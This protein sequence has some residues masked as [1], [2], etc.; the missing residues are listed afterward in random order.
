[1]N[2]R[3]VPGSIALIAILG[4]GPAVPGHCQGLG[5]LAARARADSNDE[6]LH[7]QVAMGFWKEKNWDEAETYLRNA[8]AVAPQFDR[9][10]LALG[11]LPWVRGQ[12]YWK[13]FEKMHGHEATDSAIATYAEFGRRAFLV[14]PLVDR[15]IL[16]ELKGGNAVNVGPLSLRARWIGQMRR[17]ATQVHLG[18]PAGAYATLDSA[19]HDPRFPSIYQD[20][21]F[22]VLFYHGLAAAG[23]KNWDQAIEDFGIITGR[24]VK[25]ERD[26]LDDAGYL[27][28]Q[29]N[30]FRYALATMLYLAGRHEQ[31][32][33]VFRRVLEVDLGVFPAHVQLARIHEAAG[34]AEAGIRERKQAIEVFPQNG[35]LYLELSQA[36]F[37]AGHGEDAIQTLVDG[38]AV[39]RRDYR[40]PLLLGEMLMAAGRDREARDAYIRFMGIAP[41]RLGAQVAEVRQTVAQIQ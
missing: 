14:N 24:G 31:A 35:T 8:V 27:R 28:Y 40:I 5:E 7:Y 9:A 6:Q 32:V 16:G 20:V 11:E 36:Q 41:L 17:G 15:A 21:P 10:L 39:N 2:L 1:M 29:T 23:T 38:M 30:D 22:A 34:D 37:R 19:K 12:K 26:G 3:G 33:P 18:D 13:K 25:L 4:V